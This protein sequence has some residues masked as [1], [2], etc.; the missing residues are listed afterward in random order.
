Q[1]TSL[2]YVTST[3]LQRQNTFNPYTA[4]AT[5]ASQASY[6]TKYGPASISLGATRKQYP[7]REQVDQ[8]FPTLTVSTTPIALGTWFSWTPAFSMTRSETMNM[9]QPVIGAFVYRQDPI[10][11]VLDSSRAKGRGA[12]TESITFD[13][14]LQLWGNDSRNSFRINQQRNNFLQQVQ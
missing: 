9:D 13:T 1:N 6:Q 10:T 12:I 2:N 5:I 11:G 14:P 4:L 7:G 8:T 3:T